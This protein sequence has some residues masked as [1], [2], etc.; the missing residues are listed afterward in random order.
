MAKTDFLSRI[1]SA[2][3]G[4]PNILKNEKTPLFHRLKTVETG[5][6]VIILM[7]YGTRFLRFVTN[8]Q[9]TNNSAFRIPNSELDLVPN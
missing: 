2:I 3:L 4:V 5:V 6:F 8:V 7:P 9:I 1:A